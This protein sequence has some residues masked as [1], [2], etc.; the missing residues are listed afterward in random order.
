MIRLAEGP[1][2]A[3]CLA[4]GRSMAGTSPLHDIAGDM[5]VNSSSIATAV[6]EMIGKETGHGAMAARSAL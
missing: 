1:D 5:P 4:V 2:G 6:P 3:A